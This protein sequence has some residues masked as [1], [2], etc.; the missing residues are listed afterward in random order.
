[1]LAHVAPFAFRKAV[2]LVNGLDPEGHTEAAGGRHS[3]DKVG[4]AELLRSQQGDKAAVLT[5][6][7]CKHMGTAVRIRREMVVFKIQESRR[8]ELLKLDDYP[9]SLPRS[10]RLGLGAAPM[11]PV[12]APGP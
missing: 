1:M 6:K 11:A 4:A 5:A 7:Q 8:V 9:T 2:F 3:L 12:A 10:F